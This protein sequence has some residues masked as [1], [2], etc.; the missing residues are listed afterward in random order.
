MRA[1]EGLKK[2]FKIFKDVPGDFEASVKVEKE[3]TRVFLRKIRRV[4]RRF[5][6]LQEAL[7]NFRGFSYR[8]IYGVSWSFLRGVKTLKGVSRCF[9]GLK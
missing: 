4:S 2:S 9:R 3:S 5:S 8:V 7:G 1:I 6:K